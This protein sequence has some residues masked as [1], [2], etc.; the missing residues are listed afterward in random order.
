MH[1]RPHDWLRRILGTYLLVTNGLNFTNCLNIPPMATEAPATNPQDCDGLSKQIDD[2]CKQW[3]TDAVH[4]YNKA[5]AGN[6]QDDDIMNQLKKASVE[7]FSLRSALGNRFA[8][9]GDGGEVQ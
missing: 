3:E 2:L 7:G 5:L 9:A 4:M 6:P 8:R 1:V